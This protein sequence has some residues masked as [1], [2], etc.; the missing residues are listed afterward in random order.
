MNKR[1]VNSITYGALISALLG[2]FLLVNRQLAGMFDAYM[3]WIIPIPVIIYC[4]KFDVKQ[5]MVMGVAITII[6][7]P[8][9]ASTAGLMAGSIPTIGR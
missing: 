7:P 6:L 8:L 9:F 1:R 3:L 2:A 5:G 4:L